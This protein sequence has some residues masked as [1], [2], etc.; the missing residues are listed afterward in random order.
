[1]ADTLPSSDP[2]APAQM[3]SILEN[4]GVKKA[5]TPLLAMFTLGLL[6]GAYIAIGG[7]FYELA[8]TNSGM[9][10]GPTR[11]LGGLVFSLGLI[12]VVVG[13]ADLFTGNTML[14]MAWAER[15]ISTRLLLKNW[16]V[17][18]VSN[19]IGALGIALLVF[20]SNALS[21]SDGIMLETARHVAEGKTA[22]GFWPIFYKGIL[23]NILVCMGVWLSL[24]ARNTSGKILAIML[25][26]AAFVAMG[27]E[28]CV[29]NMYLIPIGMMA[30]AEVSWAMFIHNLIPATLGNIVGGGVLVALVYWAIYIRGQQKAV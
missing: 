7:M 21:M 20:H 18:Y 1:M 11:I 26:V 17:I 15:R 22:L 4:M 25:P 24:S 29:A 8:I 3:A 14:T 16:L 5:T 28:H 6:G 13:G 30:G 9:G 2:Y 19:F 10:F 23:C 27:F 12:M